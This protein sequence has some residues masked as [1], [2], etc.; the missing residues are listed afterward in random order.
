MNFK[1]EVK[2]LIFNINDYSERSVKNVYELSVLI[3]SAVFSGRNKEFK[4]LIFIAKYVSGLKSVLS[5]KS[6]N[7][8]KYIEKIFDEFNKSLQRFFE[9]LKSA[10]SELDE[11]VIKHFNSKYFCMNQESVFNG[12]ELIEDLSLCKEYFNNNPDKLFN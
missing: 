5:N 9:L 2:D 4:D 10:V 8:D 7:G 1:D 3:D 6:I 11:N 12:M